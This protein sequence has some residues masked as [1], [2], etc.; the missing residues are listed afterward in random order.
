MTHAFPSR[1]FVRHEIIAQHG[2][3]ECAFVP[4][5]GVLRVRYLQVV[6]FIS[7]E[8]EQHAGAFPAEG[9]AACSSSLE[10]M[11]SNRFSFSGGKKR[12]HALPTLRTQDG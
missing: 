1:V 5:A 2:M 3:L 11:D 6:V 10:Q 4:A 12:D 8:K 7:M 9:T